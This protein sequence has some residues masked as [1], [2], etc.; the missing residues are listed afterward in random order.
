MHIKTKNIGRYSVLR[1]LDLSR[2]FAQLLRCSSWWLLWGIVTVESI[3]TVGEH[4]N[5]KEP[6]LDFCII[7]TYI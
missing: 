5:L 3:P 4:I 7:T 1:E 2:L 6:A